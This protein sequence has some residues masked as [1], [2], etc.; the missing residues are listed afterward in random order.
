MSVVVAAKISQEEQ[1]L[2]QAPKIIYASRTHSQIS[3]V[4][5]ELKNTPYNP[6]TC[7]LGS[8]SQL[9]IHPKVSKLSGGI[10]A[11][12]C[13]KFVSTHKCKFHEKVSG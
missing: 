4:I 12:T 8:R 3:Q 5:K 9:C 10:Q 6:R 1:V 7:I 11:Q 2:Q 13:R